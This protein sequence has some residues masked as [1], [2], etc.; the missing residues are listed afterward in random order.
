MTDGEKNLISQVLPLDK[1]SVEM[2]AFNKHSKIKFRNT[3]Y[4]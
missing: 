2:K 3:F 1:H 4:V